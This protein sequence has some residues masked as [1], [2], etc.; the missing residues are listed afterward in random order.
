MVPDDYV[1][2]Q[3]LAGAERFIMPELKEKEEMILGAE[4]RLARLEY[5]LFCELRD[6]VAAQTVRLKDVAARVAEIDV[7]AAFAQVA[8]ERRY[9]RPVVDG[10]DR[11]EIRAGRHPVVEVG[12]EDEFVPNDALLDSQQRLIILTGPNMAGKSTYLRQVALIVLLAQVGSFVPAER[13]H[14][15]V[16]DRIFTRVGASDDLAT[17]QSTFMVEMT[18]TGVICN[19][20]TERSLVL[21]DELGRGTSTYDGMA[22]A[23]AVAEYLH[24]EIRCKTI[25]STHYH[26]LTRSEETLAHCRN[27]RVDVTEERGRV[28]FLYKVVPGGADRSYGVNVARMA[29]LPR[30]ILTRAAKL[31]ARL[32]KESGAATDQLSFLDWFLAE[33]EVATAAPFSGEEEAVLDE[34]RSLRIEHLTPLE[35]LSLLDAWQ[36]RLVR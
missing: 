29:G 23:Q 14:I 26:E 4:E 5:E 6:R 24:D 31:L 10:G 32:E 27:L 21:I 30:P 1:R 12:R 11:I 22:L 17:G 7:W 9:V 35:A 3:T 15:G 28:I 33:Q 20:A 25:M 13:A 16:V 2:K 8:A 34:L 36:K 19:N 18:E